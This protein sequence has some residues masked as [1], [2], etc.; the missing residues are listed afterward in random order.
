[1]HSCDDICLAFLYFDSE[2]LKC[3]CWPEPTE[4]F[5]MHGKSILYIGLTEK[6]MEEMRIKQKGPKTIR[7]L[8]KYILCLMHLHEVFL[9]G[10]NKTWKKEEYFKSTPKS[11]EKKIAETRFY[12]D[13][14]HCP[15]GRSHSYSARRCDIFC[16]VF[17]GC[18]KGRKT[19]W[20]PQNGTWFHKCPMG[21]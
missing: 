7:Y 8:W 1:M 5:W 2:C 4:L 18:R 19:W 15:A 12:C 16:L 20:G 3:Y 14:G 11:N 21:Q 9:L 6:I 10:S 17:V 13:A